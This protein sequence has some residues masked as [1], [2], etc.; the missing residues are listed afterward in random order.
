MKLPL[1]IK[2]FIAVVSALIIISIVSN[3][4][5]SAI[6]IYNSCVDYK[7]QYDA[8]VQNQIATYS[9]NYL[10]FTEKTNITNVNKE[11][12]ITVTNI[13]MSAR[14]DGMNLAWKWNQENQQIPYEEFTSFYKDLSNFTSLRFNEN[15]NIEREKQSIVRN[16]NIV[17]TTFPGN[18]YNHFLK[19]QPLKYKAGFIDSETSKLFK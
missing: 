18:I 19:I 9:N 6:K 15:N 10:I 5:G 4:I 8:A 2:I 12:F 1:S 13:I 17:I 16:H 7:S 3:T 11:T 14:K